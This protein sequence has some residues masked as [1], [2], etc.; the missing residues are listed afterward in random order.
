MKRIMAVLLAVAIFVVTLPTVGLMAAGSPA[1]YF[2][3]VVDAN[4]MNNWTKYFDLNNITTRNAGGVWT[5]K[6][7]FTNADAFDGKVEMLDDSRNFLTALSALAAN[8]EVVGYSTVPTDTVLVLDLSGSM[9]N[10][11]SEDDLIDA[12]NAAIAK[13]LEVNEN[14]R[15]GVVLYSASGSVGVSSYSESVTRILPI[16]RYTTGRDNQYLRLSNNGRVSVDGDVKGT[17]AG[18]DLDNT[19]VF[20]GGTYIQAGL[21]E[22]KEMFEEMDTVIGDNNW[23]SG[24]NRMPILVL[25]SDGACSTGTTNY[26][27]V[28]RSN[29]GNGDESGLTPGNAFL[30]QLTASY[31]MNRIEAHYQGED[32]DVRGLFYT[33]GFNIAGNSVA[34]AVMNPDASKYTDDL[35]TSYLDPRTQN[36]TVSVK[37]T[38]S[39]GTS[40]KDVSINKNSYV[41]GKSYVDEYFSASGTGLADAFNSIVE[42]IILQSR[43]YPTHLE[44]GSPDF[45]GYV[46]FTDTLGE[47]MEIK[48]INGI[49]LGDTLFDGHMMASKLNSAADGGLGS[50]ENPTTLGDEFVRSVKTR[51]GISDTATAQN[52]IAD[53]FAAKQLCY[54]TIGGE[55]KWSN[56]IGWYAKEDM[57]F[58]SFCNDDPSSPAPLT[59][60]T[61]DEV[62]KVRSYGF[63]GE[64][65]GSIKNSDMMYMSV[66]VRTNL[67]TGEQTVFWKIPASLVPLVTYEVS[68]EGTN[69]DEARNVE[70]S[71]ENA[72]KVSPIRLIFESGLRSDLNELNITRITDQAHLADDGVTRI[73][74]NNHFDISAA[75]HEEHVTTLSE[76][77]PSKENERFYFTFD[78]AVHK[79]VGNNYLLVDENEGFGGALDQNGEYYHRRYIFTEDSSTP[80]FVYEKMSAA[81]IAAATWKSDFVT[82]TGDKG[83]WVVPSGTPARELKM[84]SELKANEALTQS[85]HMVFYPY[86]IEQNN[87]HYVDMNLGNNGLLSVTPAQGIKISKTIDV[88]EEGTSDVFGFLITAKGADG[89]PLSGSFNTYVDAIGSTP[90]TTPTPKSFV[91]GK[92][93]LDLKAN[94]TFWL[95]GLPSGA[96]YTVEEISDNADYKLKSVH[97][98]GQATGATAYGT[99]AAYFID[100]VSFVNTAIGEGNLVITKQV[101]DAA[102]NP[103]HVNDNV[104]FTAEVTLTD[105]RGNP[106]SGSF[107]STA[108]TLTVP[109]NGRFTVTLSDGGSFVVRGIPEET[110]YTVAETNIPAGFTFDANRSELSGVIDT[111]ASGRALIVNR[112]TPVATDGSDVEVIVN[113]A[114]SGNRTHWLDGESYTFTLELVS[115]PHAA[116]IVGNKTISSADAEKSALFE[117]SSETYTSAD[118]YTYAIYES[119]GDRGGIT[120]DTAIRRFSIVVADSDMDGDLEIAS[121]NNISGTAVSGSYVVTADFNNVYAPSGTAT[122][123]IDVLKRMSS[124]HSLAGYQFALYDSAALENEILR[125]TVTGADG[126]A[127]F[128]LSYAA[129]RASMAGEVYTY[130]MAELNT[131]NPNISYSKEVY[132]VEVTVKDNGDGTVSATSKITDVNGGDIPGAPSFLN[133]YIPSDSDYVTITGT[134]E[135]SG[136]RI[137]NSGEFSFNISADTQG[138]PLPTETT[139]KNSADGSF[140]FPAIEFTDAHKGQSF[141][142][143]VTESTKDKL[144]GFTYDSASF[145]VYVSV[146]DNGDA[147]LT[148]EIEKIEKITDAVS[149]VS[150]IRFVNVYD[151]T[152]AEVSLGGT[153]LLTGKN[154]QNGEFSFRLEAITQGAPMPANATVSNNGSGGFTFGKITYAKAG[155]YR[156]RLYEVS[157]N[158]SRYDFDKSVYTVTVTVT[159]NSVGKLSAEVAL[160][161]NDLAANEIVFRNGFN[162]SPISYDIYTDFGGTKELIGRPLEN[163]EFEFNLINAIDGKQIGD[164]VKND[165]NG[166]FRF[167]ALTLSTTGVYHFKITETVGDEIG[168]SY[169]TTSFHIR[170]EVAQN[171][172]G[173]LNIVDKK[174]YKANVTKQEV[175]GVLTEVTSYDNITGQGGI[176]FENTYKGRAV[177]VS[178]EATKK[179]SGRELTDGEFSFD[180]YAA[181]SSY[182][183]GALIEDNATNKEGKV[184]FEELTFTDAGDYFFIILEDEVDGKGVT[185]DKQ[186]YKIRV[187]VTDDLSG[188]MIADLYVNDTLVSEF[189][190]D[191]IVFNNSYKAAPAE[192]VIKGSKTYQGATLSDDMFSFELY[193]ADGKLIETVKNK[194]EDVIFTAIP[195]EEAGR[196]LYTVK[197]VKGDAEN[198]TYDDTVYTVTVTVTDN[199][200]GTMTASYAYATDEG[201]CEAIGFVNT[202]APPVETPETGDYNNVGLWI[203]LLFVSGGVFAGANVY[204]MKRKEN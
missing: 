25:M 60:P 170:L 37:S 79:K 188:F 55:L 185:N 142:Y 19:K 116:K 15:V 61:T 134:K 66:Q 173:V 158:D 143:T 119:E 165:A 12:A 4:T 162:P 146:I 155:V 27:N 199:L 107:E 160:E 203:A 136:D 177:D 104:K 39:T 80:V 117:L 171:D 71:V 52:L 28:G 31:V 8:K 91:N 144:G 77:T 87:V 183:K 114:I 98:N 38:S 101:V 47:Y 53:A 156:Y 82:L 157:S 88:Y 154:L 17:I 89:A 90:S 78:S 182:T 152:D 63:L 103:A 6:S 5:D 58:S 184:L 67:Q 108:G 132:K 153:K 124:N 40:Y 121:V 56:Y 138:A 159:D 97:V 112:Y 181:D 32:S 1:Q 96:T 92:L 148:A 95:T 169:D 16:D 167:P 149:T 164:S 23:Q 145:K 11:N 83:A 111:T 115:A 198:V 180:L 130:Y 99:V 113:K 24:D 193:G 179:L 54:E 76:F 147:T 106:V 133:T 18:A 168:V 94:E 14:N 65:S 26:A 36:L 68:L 127:A 141:V 178:L 10:S 33:L 137:L 21:W 196:Y 57:T 22:A 9:E 75:D 123:T 74:W 109:A 135:I 51:L 190:S 45:S 29:V 192:I 64:T 140:T 42:E 7:V 126:L 166:E 150:D 176:T 49:L 86:L 69:V 85:A 172:S 102:G 194:G 30:T 110:R 44:G 161:K 187:S 59:T 120:Y 35:W 200:D 197:E 100:D 201:D 50:I 43:Y 139:V 118:T 174:L 13:L 73:F 163:G 131:G 20:G 189:I 62:Y 93:E 191:S 204:R 84:Y 2:D 105:G 34:Q 151:A 175:G 128:T 70:V 195:V 202:Y 186:E 81:S 48:H 3:R 129:N 46:E 122:V 125:S 41:T 72:D